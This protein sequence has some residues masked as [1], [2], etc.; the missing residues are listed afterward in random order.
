MKNDLNGVGMLVGIGIIICGLLL[1]IL[2]AA[3]PSL[4]LQGEEWTLINMLDDNDGLWM[5]GN[6]DLRIDSAEG[7]EVGET[8]ES[9]VETNFGIAF[10]GV[11]FIMIGLAFLARRSKIE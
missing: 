6:D 7:Y 10:L 1:L 5:N 2:M 9:E 11:V 3:Q 8:Y 4:L